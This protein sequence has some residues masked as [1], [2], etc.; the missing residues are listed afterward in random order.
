MNSSTILRNIEPLLQP[1][2]PVTCVHAHCSRSRCQLYMSTDEIKPGYFDALEA[3][4]PVLHWADFF[5]AR[6]TSA[7]L[8]LHSCCCHCRCFSW[9]GNNALTNITIPNP[10]KLNGLFEQVVVVLDSQY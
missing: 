5:T 9:P 7:A 4:H 8:L 10:Q 6:G 1:H 2:E 3:K